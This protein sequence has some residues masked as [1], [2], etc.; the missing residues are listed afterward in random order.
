[1]GNIFGP[2][3]M[4]Y[5]SRHPIRVVA[6]TYEEQVKQWRAALE[7]SIKRNLATKNGGRKFR[8]RVGVLEKNGKRLAKPYRPSVN[9]S[10]SVE[11][12][13]PKA[14]ALPEECFRRRQPLNKNVGRSLSNIARRKAIVAAVRGGASMWSVAGRFAVS[15]CTVQRW[16]ARGKGKSLE[17]RRPGRPARRVP[18]WRPTRT[19]RVDSENCCCG[20]WTVR[21]STPCT[22]SSPD[23]VFPLSTACGPPSLRATRSTRTP[24]SSG[25]TTSR[26]ARDG[27]RTSAGTST[28]SRKSPISR[29]FTGRRPV[30]RSASSTPPGAT[31]G[32]CGRWS[33]SSHPSRTTS[34][35][36]RSSRISRSRSAS[37]AGR[38]GRTSSACR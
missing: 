30:A 26:S 35:V 7:K 13:Q 25:R 36:G 8:I 31:I 18:H 20:G 24:T 5:D 4:T 19:C 10:G 2:V 33:A 37:L 15:L 29:C 3:A 21:S 34:P 6:T 16:V 12:Q 28:R 17:P 9:D 14:G 22:D 32:H 38:R 23:R 27:P 1:M 11:C